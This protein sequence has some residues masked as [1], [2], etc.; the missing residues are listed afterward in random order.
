MDV[1]LAA[2]THSA[3]PAGSVGPVGEGLADGAALVDP[4]VVAL[5]VEPPEPKPHAAATT[6]AAAKPN[7]TARRRPET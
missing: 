5:G 2:L 1:P 7:S 3:Q 6:A 4:G